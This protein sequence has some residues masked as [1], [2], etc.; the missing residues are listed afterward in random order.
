[1][2]LRHDT[3]RSEAARRKLLVQGWRFIHHSYAIVAQAHALAF[4]RRGDVDVRFQ[5]LPFPVEGWKTSRGIL[6]PAD[7]REISSLRAPEAGFAADATLRFAGDFSRP[8]S[9]RAFVFDTPECRVLRPGVVRKLKEGA[10]RDASVHI[11]VPSRWAG[12]AYLRFGIPPERVHVVPHGVDPRVLHPDDARRSATRG[13]LEI[14]GRFVF[15]SVGAMTE[16]KGIDLLLPAFARVARIRVEAWLVLKGADDLYGSRDRLQRSLDAL[17]PT[18]RE[19]VASRLT[20]LGDRRSAQEMADL[21]R[22]ADCYVS[23]YRAEG[24]NM[25]VLEAA[26]CGVPVICTAGGATDDFVEPSFA[27]GIRARPDQVLTDRGVLGE[28][29]QPDVEHLAELMSR[30]ADD[31]VEARRMGEAGAAHAAQ[32]FTWD[33]VTARLHDVL[34]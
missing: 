9:G 4:L 20:Y 30:A 13:R 23:P 5:H 22:A 14:D 10:A 1:M 32:G 18:D 31:P 29:L 28:I 8:R 25:P 15:L 33:R 7:E 12:D 27:W 24:F 26:A 34:F 11:L 19:A 17:S 21:L 2:H 6:D 3:S 16:N